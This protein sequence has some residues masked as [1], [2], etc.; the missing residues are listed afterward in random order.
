MFK[1]WTQAIQEGVFAEI[2]LGCRGKL[3]VSPM[4]YGPYDR[5]NRLLKIYRGHGVR[6][7]AMLVSADEAARKS[8]RDLFTLYAAAGIGVIH[9]PIA[10]LT[11]PTSHGIDELLTAIQEALSRHHV[12]MHCNAG[13]GRTGVVAACLVQRINGSTGEAALAYVQRY[14]QI[15]MTDEQRRFVLVWAG[16]PHLRASGGLNHRAQPAR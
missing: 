2:P 11:A 12:A 14:M 5:F 15:N 3:Y 13:V 6:R 4:P 9:Y 1:R 16:R 10:D 8:R 7:V